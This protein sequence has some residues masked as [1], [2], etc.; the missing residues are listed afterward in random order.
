[1][2]RYVLMLT[3]IVVTL[4]ATVVTPFFC[5]VVVGF[6]SVTLLDTGGNPAFV[7]FLVGLLI[8][9]VVLTAG[10]L[11]T[12]QLD[13]DW[14]RKHLDGRCP[15]CAYLLVGNPDATVC[16]ECGCAFEEGWRRLNGGI[17]VKTAQTGNSRKF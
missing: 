17:M 13:N 7:A 1:M 6:F 10:L 3:S 9:P 12:Y 2:G 15:K 14:E 16:P 11:I 8:T 4:G 5:A